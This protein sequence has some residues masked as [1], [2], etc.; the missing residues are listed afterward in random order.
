MQGDN[1]S[2][3]F[4]FKLSSKGVLIAKLECN[5]KTEENVQKIL[6]DEK[7]NDDQKIH[8]TV[9]S[10]FKVLYWIYRKGRDEVKRSFSIATLSSLTP[11]YIRIDNIGLKKLSNNQERES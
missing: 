8:Y 4:S 3:D 1:N 11:G 10:A 9:S 6:H 7:L 2:E 5:P